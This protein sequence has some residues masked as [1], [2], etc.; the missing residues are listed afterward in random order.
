MQHLLNCRW[1]NWL[2]TCRWL[3]GRT[4]LAIWVGRSGASWQFSSVNSLNAFWQDPDD[5]KGSFPPVVYIC[6]RPRLEIEQVSVDAAPVSIPFPTSFARVAPVPR[7]YCV[8]ISEV[9][10]VDHL[11]HLDTYLP[12]L[13][14]VH[15]TSITGTRRSPSKGTKVPSSPAAMS[16]WDKL[17]AS[18]RQAVQLYPNYH[19]DARYK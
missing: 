14:A 1:P 6:L 2:S 13:A 10:R 3:Q 11:Q 7:V 18:K 4:A 15:A 19:E 12:P 9:L 17:A 8:F 5:P 16:P